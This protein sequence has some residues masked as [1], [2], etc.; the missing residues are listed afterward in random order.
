MA[1][2]F[3]DVSAFRRNPLDLLLN[4]AGDSSLGFVPLHLGLRPMWLVTD[5]KLA[6][7]V[8]KWPTTQIDK[9]R[10]VQTITPLVGKS[11]LTNVGEAHAKSKSA[12]HRHVH[13]SGVISN[14]DR[15]V[16]IINQFVARVTVSG[17]VETARELPELAF[18]LA[19]VVVFGH[20]AITAADR[21]L[22]VQAVRTVEAEVADSIFRLPFMPRLPWEARKHADRLSY[23]RF[24]IV[25][26]VKRVRSSEK[27]SGVIRGLEEAGL[28]DEDI[29][30]EVLGLLIAGHH[31]TGAT[32]GWLLHH[33]AV[34][35][36]I[37][38]MIGI[39][40][41][42][43]MQKLEENDVTALKQAPLSE[44]YISEILRL[45]PA[46]WWTSR[47]VFEPIEINGQKFRVGDMFM[48]SP[49]Q[50]HRDH[51]LWAQPSEFKLDR[52]FSGEA[53]MPFGIGPRACIGMS[54]AWFELQ[55]FT[56]LVAGSLRFRGTL[57]ASPAPVP[58]ITLLYPGDVFEVKPRMPSTRLKMTG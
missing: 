20:D 10:L 5:P 27:R 40:A 18:Q 41:D 29:S 35:P 38:E 51:R 4:R 48:V 42:Q 30:A 25:Q 37:A 45:Y 15:M 26:V 56:L 21:T 14:I 19:C 39:E 2:P 52:E 13:R 16:A 57:E 54:I 33:L 7:S 17:S 32:M 53:Y 44:A 23:A 6:R 47:E 28:N 49:W 22:L 46:G 55:L 43:A 11:L 1:M 31:T 36:E 34:D 24:V 3:S 50:M 8:L 9:G 58:S 12:M